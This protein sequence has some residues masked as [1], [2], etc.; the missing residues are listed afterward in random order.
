MTMKMGLTDAIH[1]ALNQSP[2]DSPANSERPSVKLNTN[3][4]SRPTQTRTETV[5]ATKMA[6]VM[7]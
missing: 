6:P 2:K 1:P 4:V 5:T 3:E 7:R